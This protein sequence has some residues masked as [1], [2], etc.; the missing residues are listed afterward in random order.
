M[1]ELARR[2]ND[3]HLGQRKQRSN[4]LKRDAETTTRRALIGCS[5]FT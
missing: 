1:T 2:D 4:G 5:N 3:R